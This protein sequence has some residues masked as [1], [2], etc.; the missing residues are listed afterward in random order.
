MLRKN[1]RQRR[2]YLYTLSKEREQTEKSDK[3]M[4]VHEAKVSGKQVPTELLKEKQKLE[5]D[6]Q[7][8]DANTIGSNTVI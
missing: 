5:K 4:K 2:E 8:V 6:L 7:K 1:I 3:L